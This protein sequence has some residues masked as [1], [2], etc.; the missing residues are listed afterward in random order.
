MKNTTEKI[1][2]KKIREIE[3]KFFLK[4]KDFFLA[5]TSKKN[6]KKFLPV[7]AP[8]PFL[9]KKFQHP[10]NG[11]KFSFAQKSAQGGPKG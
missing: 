8:E 4:T 5:F 1:S 6:F 3:K 10:K 7:L 2:W 11:Q 9:Q